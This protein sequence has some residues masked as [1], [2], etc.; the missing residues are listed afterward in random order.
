MKKL[1]ALGLESYACRK[2][3]MQD[4]LDGV[5]GSYTKFA[6]LTE[7]TVWRSVRVIAASCQGMII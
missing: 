3:S 4:R 5:Q 7:E 1:H 6:G 2:S